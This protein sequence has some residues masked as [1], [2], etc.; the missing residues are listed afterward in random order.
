[1]SLH[2]CN[3]WQ[4][5]DPH[6]RS[7]WISP[8]RCVTSTYACTNIHTLDF[9]H[10]CDLRAPP[11]V[12]ALTEELKSLR[13]LPPLQH[14]RSPQPPISKDVMSTPNPNQPPLPPLDPIITDHLD[15]RLDDAVANLQWLITEAFNSGI[16]PIQQEV[17]DITTQ[18][19]ARVTPT[20][21]PRPS[22]F[23]ANPP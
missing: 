10:Q 13:L 11:C 22:S 7:L 23:K 19:Q 5:R 21:P 18:L 4:R 3:T 14:D 12:V 8:T 9:P 2:I 1:M 15:R 6:F 16:R 17:A 20:Q